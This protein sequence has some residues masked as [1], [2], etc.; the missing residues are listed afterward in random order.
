MAE[1]VMMAL[2]PFRFEVGQATYQSLAMRQS[3]RWPEQARIGREPALQYTGREPIEVTLSGT[4]YPSFDGGLA[5]VEQMRELADKGE[6]LQLVDGLGRVWGAW[7]IVEVG[8]TRSVLMDDGQPRRIAFELKLKS[9]GED[10]IVTD[11]S[12]GW[13]PFAVLLPIIDEVATDPLDALNTVVGDVVRRVAGSMGGSVIQRASVLQDAVRDVM[14]PLR[15]AL[16]GAVSRLREA[17]V[18]LPAIDALLTSV[19]RASAAPLSS[20]DVMAAQIAA[21]RDDIERARREAERHPQAAELQEVLG[22]AERAL[23]G[24]VPAEQETA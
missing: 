18:T 8:D 5:Q 11:I 4:L 16:N 20:Y 23:Q 6:P 19:A 13:S 10:N 15:T 9:Y 14:Q 1:R 3:W 22:S 2:G 17:G 7:A 21:L 24:L 12:G